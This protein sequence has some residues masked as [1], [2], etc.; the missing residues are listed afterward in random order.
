MVYYFFVG[1]D[2]ITNSHYERTFQDAKDRLIGGY[3]QRWAYVTFETYP[4]P[5]T[6]DAAECHEGV[7]DLVYHIA[8]HLVSG[9]ALTGD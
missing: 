3:A 4:D 9:E 8:E 7:A 5:K 6:M 1:K 2:T